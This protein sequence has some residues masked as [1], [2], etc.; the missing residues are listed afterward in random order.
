MKLSLSK[1]ILT[2]GEVVFKLDQT[3]IEESL[4]QRFILNVL[5]LNS[6]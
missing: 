1:D 4:M 5:N 3:F 6:P 2:L